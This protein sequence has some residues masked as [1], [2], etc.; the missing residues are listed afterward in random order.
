MLAQITRMVDQAQS[1]RAPM[2]RLADRASAIFVPVVLGLAAVTFAA[3]LIAGALAAAGAGEHGCGAGDCLPVRDGAGR[4]GR[5]DRGRGPRRAAGRAVQG[6]R[7]AGAAGAPGRDRP[8]QDG[9]ADGGTAGAG[10]LGFAWTYAAATGN[11]TSEL[12]RMAAAAE[13][14]SNHP[15]AHAMIDR[16]AGAWARSGSRRRTCRFFPAAASRRAWKGTNACWATRRCSARLCIALPSD[17]A[18]PEPGV[19][20]LW[21]ALDSAAAGLLR[22]ARCAAA[23]CGRGDCRAAA[24]RACAC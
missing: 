11:R 15:L 2:E 14:R 12:L 8:G 9:N 13:E 22:C 7:S 5:A 21:M 4:A 6:R 1:S 19:T 10:R 20:R 24:T 23:R 17:V 18:A 16:C 3:W